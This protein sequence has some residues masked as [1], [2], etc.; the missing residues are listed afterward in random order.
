MSL[1]EEKGNPACGETLSLVEEPLIGNVDEKLLVKQKV[2]SSS[3]ERQLT[4]KGKQMREQDAKK[5]LKAFLRAYESWKKVAREARIILKGFCVKDDLDNINE[6]VQGGYD[7]VNQ[8]YEVMQRNS[9]NTLDVVQKMD[10][11]NTLTTEICDLVSKRFEVGLDQGTFKEEVEK[12]R[13]RMILNKDEYKSIFGN[14]NTESI[15][16]EKLDNSSVISSKASSNRVDA[17]ADLAAKL[18]QA[19][20]MQGI[21]AQAAKLSKLESEQKFHESQ[22]VAEIKRKQAENEL[23][24]EEE[25]TKLKMMQVD[26]DVKVAAARVRTYNQIEDNVTR[27]PNTA[28]FTAGTTLDANLNGHTTVALSQLHATSQNLTTN[29]AEAIASSLSLNRLPVPEPT[30]FAG[31]PLKFVDFKMSFTILIDRKPIPVSEKML[32]LKSY[33]TGEARKAVEGFFY[34]SSEDAYEGAWS[35]LKDRYGNPFAVQ[36]AYRDKLMKWPKIGPN[37]FLALRDFADSLNGCAEAMPHV[38]GLAILNDSEENHKLLK[39]LPDWAVRKWSR[40][41]VEE[42][43]ASGEYPTFKCFAEFVQKEAR[44]ACN[45]ITSSLLLSSRSVDDKLPKRAKTFSTSAQMKD[46][47]L[48]TSERPSAFKP[49]LPCLVCKEEF[50]GIAKCPAFA[51]KS[52]GDKR[53]FIHQNH[54]CFGCLRKGHVTKDCRTRHIC[55]ICGRRHPTCLHEEREREE[56]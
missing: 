17:E 47:K 37:D 43:D 38:K 13:V 32:Y 9:L 46:H 21:Q 25:R 16:S 24:L 33:L 27:E 2:R 39:K 49:K 14:T 26:M 22:M 1:L 51:S 19:K 12:E 29:L 36:K 8:T 4:E 34:R 35:V 20:S 45:P 3:R 41:V 54:L 44:I 42:L 31:D 5:H 50:H 28:I 56:G 6:T 48:K 52:K 7:C 10:A 23:K 53:A 30:I 18:E 40:I 15:M 55:G 11:C